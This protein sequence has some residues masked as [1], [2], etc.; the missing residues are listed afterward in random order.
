MDAKRFG[1]FSPSGTCSSTQHPVR[2]ARTLAEKA[3]FIGLNLLLLP[4]VLM[5]YA[6]VNA[7]GLIVF[8]P[9]FGTPLYRIPSLHWVQD[10][11]GW[12][13]LNLGHVTAAGLLILLLAVWGW[14]IKHVRGVGGAEM[15]RT[16][17]TN[18]FWFTAATAAA[19]IG[20]EAV[21]FFAGLVAVGAA[22]GAAARGSQPGCSQCCTSE[23]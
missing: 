5:I 8:Q 17:E 6:T 18:F 19:L 13:R 12:N 16:F 3:Q 15:Q 21:I 9:V 14:V 22:S 7:E 10:F 23:E 11:A 20:I 4:L 2:S 1:N